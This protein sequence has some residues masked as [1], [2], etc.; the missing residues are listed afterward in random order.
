MN[1]SLHPEVVAE[2]DSAR[3]VCIKQSIELNV[4]PKGDKYSY[5]WSGPGGFT[6][7]LSSPFIRSALASAEGTYSVTVTDNIT[8]CSG[9]ATTYVKVGNDSLSLTNVTSDQTIKYG[10]SIQ[11]NA[12]NAVLFTWTPND[13]SLDNPNINNP[14]A[15]PLE[16]TTYIVHGVGNNGCI[17]TASVTIDIEF[18]DDIFIPSAFTPNGDGL[19]DVFRVS[20]KRYFKVIAMSVFNRWGE[21]VYH[22]ENGSNSG[23]DGT[24]K[25][26]ASDLGTYSYNIT[27][28]KSEGAIESYKGN[29]TLVR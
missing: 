25:G 7:M 2:A 22:V 8:H 17:D 28:S 26:L 29:V 3:S 21:L 9:K 13:G 14:I 19:N 20:G 4:L 12:S 18:A 6:S 11:L 27:L 24:Y 15:T 23:W 1:I 16:R 5:A 10:S